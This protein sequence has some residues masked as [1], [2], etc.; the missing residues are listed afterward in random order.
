MI[1]VLPDIMNKASSKAS[2]RRGMTM[3]ELL[4]TIAIIIIL[5]AVAFISVMQYQ[6]M[7]A[8][9]ERDKVAKDIYF[10]AQNHLI[11]S[12][13]EGYL[14]LGKD[15]NTDAKKQKVYGNSE[16]SGVYYFVHT[17]GDTDVN[18]SGSILNLML[19]FGSIDETVRGSGSY[20]V[21]YNSSIGQVLDIFYCTANGTRFGYNLLGTVAYDKLISYSSDGYYGDGNKVRRR[22]NFNGNKSVLGWYGGPKA[23][24]G[25]VTELT[26][27]KIKVTNADTLYV[28]VEDQNPASLSVNYSIKLIITG[29]TSGATK[30][31]VLK[32]S[33]SSTSL[34]TIDS[35]DLGR[36]DTNNKKY[37]IVLDDITT[38]DMHFGSLKADEGKFIPGEDI[39]IQAVTY[40]LDGLASIEYSE[41][42]VT[43]SLFASIGDK[44]NGSEG[45]GKLDT[46]Y[47]SSIRHLENLDARVSNLDANDSDDTI[48]ISDA[49]QTKDLKWSGEDSFLSNV[50]STSSVIYSTATGDGFAPNDSN[51]TP[52]GCYKPVI[53]PTLEVGPD[54]KGLNY[55]G[56]MHSITGIKASEMLDLSGDAGLFES[57]TGGTV[58]NLQLI[59]FD[60]ES[61]SNKSAGAL[62]GTI[63]GTTITNVVARNSKDTNTNATNTLPTVKSGI[64][65]GLVGNMINGTIRY[66]AAD[67]IVNGSSTAGGLV[68]TASSG[69]IDG[70]YSAG[71]TKDGSYLDW[72]Y[73]DGDKTKGKVSNH[74]YDVIGPTAGGLIGSAGSATISNSY[75]T[76]SVSGTTAGGF[77]GSAGGSISNCYATGLIDTKY[78]P[79][80]E[81]TTE[82]GT[83]GAFAGVFSGRIPD[84]DCHY[85]SIINEVKMNDE[86][87]TFD[88]YLG[89]IGDKTDNSIKAIDENTAKYDDFVNGKSAWKP[90]I[91]YDDTLE[92]Y[93]NEHYNLKTVEQLSDGELSD[94]DDPPYSD[95]SD[96]FIN[97]HYGDWPAPEVFIVNE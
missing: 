94:E 18:D 60:I 16:G 43:N 37:T 25:S 1:R 67:L 73:T 9:L 55:D 69:I 38:A 52:S 29:K 57:I 28:E 96:L 86:D 51:K 36:I 41:E 3:A 46:V 14:E 13:G 61:K 34:E 79:D 77:V 49:V 71:H 66:S 19:P 88:H 22:N 70:C 90:A 68:G 83:I 75:S 80:K 50:G 78:I 87:H 62:A 20:I 81:N 42:N 39:A 15:A 17:P 7:L 27:P 35:D 12:R 82:N 91:P 93:Y 10:A 4:I 11:A 45:D 63:N 32:R 58:R 47:I 8:Q 56:K 40:S 72:I 53:P 84:N 21:R 97:S 59:D 2:N 5:A 95:W 30:G 89:A 24:A 26:A 31:I 6:R 76:C 33:A 44:N 85:Y 54:K 74:D 92:T 64:V 23:G 65:G 48:Q